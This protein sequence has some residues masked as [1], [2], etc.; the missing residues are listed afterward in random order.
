MNLLDVEV[1]CRFLIGPGNKCTWGHR[2][3]GT[4]DHVEIPELRKAIGL[5]VAESKLPGGADATAAPVAA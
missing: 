1:N 4:R 3:E 2:M 5:D